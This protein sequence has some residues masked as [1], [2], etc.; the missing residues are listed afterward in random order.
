MKKKRPNHYAWPGLTS[1]NAVYGQHYSRD[2]E[3]GQTEIFTF[4]FKP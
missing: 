1:Y 4:L 3:K 2:E